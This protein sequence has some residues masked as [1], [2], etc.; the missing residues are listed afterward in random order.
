MLGQAI[1]QDASGAHRDH[2]EVISEDAVMMCFKN[3]VSSNGKTG[4]LERGKVSKRVRNEMFKALHSTLGVAHTLGA[5]PGGGSG[6]G[7]SSS[8][9]SSSSSSSGSG[10]WMEC[11]QGRGSGS[12]SSA[13]SSSSRSG[14][15]G[16]VEADSGAIGAGGGP[17]GM[18]PAHWNG[19]SAEDRRIYLLQRDLGDSS[20]EVRDCK[21][22]GEGGNAG[23]K[24]DSSKKR[25]KVV[26]VGGGANESSGCRTTEVGLLR[27]V[28]VSEEAWATLSDA[29]RV[30]ALEL[31]RPAFM[32][33]PDWGRM[34]HEGRASIL[35]LLPR[36]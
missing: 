16:W 34:S 32:S 23:G 8:N 27:P 6:S 35:A 31:T 36:A 4:Q 3:F 30:E 17:E 9:S 7:G 20:G 29:E 24:L 10:G 19:M 12:S 2:I 33:M 26:V 5:T 18:C 14:S 25:S 13:S 28:D 1:R 15:V 11:E 21:R 22:V